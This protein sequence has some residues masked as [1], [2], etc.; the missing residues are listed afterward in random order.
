[1]DIH[2]Y[3]ILYTIPGLI[4]SILLFVQKCIINKPPNALLL[5]A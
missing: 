4:E 3:T 1:M 2:D 5:T